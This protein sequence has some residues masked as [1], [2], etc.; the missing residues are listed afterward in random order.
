V[1]SSCGCFAQTIRDDFGTS[2]PFKSPGGVHLIICAAKERNLLLM[3]QP[4]LLSQ[5]GSC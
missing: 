5:E 1:D 3:A 2:M 4:P